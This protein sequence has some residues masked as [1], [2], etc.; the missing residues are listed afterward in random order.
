MSITSSSS[1]ISSQINLFEKKN[2]TKNGLNNKNI[3]SDNI[4][5]STSTLPKIDTNNK[6][7]KNNDIVKQWNKAER[8]LTL[9]SFPKILNE[10]KRRDKMEE[11]T[12][13]YKKR[14][15]KFLKSFENLPQSGVILDNSKNYFNIF[16]PLYFN[17]SEC[18]IQLPSPQLLSRGNCIDSTNCT[19]TFQEFCNNYNILE[20]ER[21]KFFENY[22]IS[23]IKRRQLLELQKKIKKNEKITK[24][25]LDI[26]NNLHENELINNFNEMTDQFATLT[27]K[28]C[29]FTSIKEKNN[30]KSV[31]KDN[32]IIK[33]VVNIENTNEKEVDRQLSNIEYQINEINKDINKITKLLEE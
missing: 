31:I 5:K 2:K 24:S 25:F 10:R 28:L 4:L 8:R 15:N 3:S 19:T 27:F 11:E 29:H 33:D 13:A 9:V 26:E 23:I 1:R 21:E 6:K 22:N 32:W 7:I 12:Q 18:T 14:Q 20:D 16:F 30:N 17:S